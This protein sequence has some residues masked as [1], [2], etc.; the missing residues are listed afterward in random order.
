MGTVDTFI[1]F[2]RLSDM[3]VKKH[4][5]QLYNKAYRGSVIY[6]ETGCFSGLIYL[7]DVKKN[8]RLY[9]HIY[10]GY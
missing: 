5:G 1:V 9:N 7:K 6:T 4:K 8:F 3:G 2:Q 10:Y